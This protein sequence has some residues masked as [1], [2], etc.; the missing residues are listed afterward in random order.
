[1]KIK[2]KS[3]IAV[4]VTMLFT[5][6]CSAQNDH[7]E[8]TM[9]NLDLL[10]LKHQYALN[11]RL[12]KN[13]LESISEEEA[14]RRIG[15]KTN[16]IRW[17]TGHFLDIQYNLA[18]LLGLKDNNP[19][20]DQFGFGKPFDPNGAYPALGEMLEDSKGLSPEIE[21]A[22]AAL[23]RETLNEEAPFPLPYGEQTIRGLLAFQMHHM[24]YEIGQIGIYR[25]FLGKS[26][27]S[28]Q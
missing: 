15:D 3:T 14:D 10:I 25:K 22:I 16:S 17:I 5:T 6:G 11:A 9:E 27:M 20:A 8:K 18:M 2:I 28:Y 23:P 26:G 1:M 24:S 21:N 19:Y 4:L 7:T 12:L 13:V